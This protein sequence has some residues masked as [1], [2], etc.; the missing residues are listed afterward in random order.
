MSTKLTTIGLA[1]MIAASSTLCVASSSHKD[2]SKSDLKGADS[3]QLGPR[4][5][6]LVNDMDP[7]P[8]KSKL[9]SCKKGPFKKTDF[10]IG[11]RG[12]ALQFP[13]HT[14]ESYEAA[15]R[16]GAGIL[17]CDVTFTKD[18]ELVCRHSQCDLHTTTNILAT[19][20]AA[21]CSKQFIPAAYDASGKMVTPASAQC[22]TSDITLAEFKT[23]RGK[24]DA[25]NSAATSV[26][27]YLGGTA[28]FRTDL[29]SGPS[30]GTLMTHKESIALFKKLGTKMTPELKSASVTMPFD[31]F[32]QQAYAQK[33]IDEYKA[34]GV[35][36][37]H[38]WPQSFDQR[39]VL[40]WVNNEAAFGKQAV[41]L[42]DA[43]TVA[44]L[45]SYEQLVQYKS[46][47]IQIV[48]PPTFAL[49]ALDAGGRIVPS[50]YARNAKSAGLDIITWTLERS[51][52]LADGN[53]GFYYQGIDPAIK[54]E[55]DMMQVI[56]VLA[57]E[58]GVLGIF[59]D[60]PATT[61]FYANCA[62]LR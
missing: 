47:G 5:I 28:N 59:S 41:Y 46:Q 20:L 54:T 24:M 31:G 32:T 42:D 34:A 52:I 11:H 60:W 45:P 49:L 19:P 55:G 51:G 38:V 62:G 57:R 2:S 35:P 29:Y 56:D 39:D 36:A 1:V 16:M 9:E 53:N 22:C 40:Y 3:V 23:L 58:V 30:S 10:S 17:E 27:D 13:E 44:D 15:A 43:N 50:Q 21:K 33:M 48:A 26:A 25:S 12:A 8:L 18:K 6:F 4:P 37:R 14:Q 61:T 7:S